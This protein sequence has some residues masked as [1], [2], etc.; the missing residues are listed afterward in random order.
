MKLPLDDSPK[1]K[2]RAR[3]LAILWTLL[4]FFLCFIPAD[5][6]P[7]VHIPLADKWTHFI[8]FGVFA[9]LWLLSIPVFKN[10]YLVFIFLVSVVLGWLVEF[11]QGLLVFLH[12]SEDI[13]DVAAD[14][15]G[16][17]LGVMIFYVIYRMKHR[18]TN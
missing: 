18:K 11:I 16:G 17:L 13:T 5:D 1:H 15:I 12:R 2:K 6:I 10:R 4:I 7:D 14:T 8:L 9:F 3:L